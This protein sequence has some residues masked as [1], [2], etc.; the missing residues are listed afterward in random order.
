[1]KKLLEH[2][3]KNVPPEHRD[4]LIAVI[5]KNPDFFKQLNTEIEKEVKSGKSQMKASMEVMRKHQAELQK[6][7]QD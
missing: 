3:L 1:M 7:M 4:R 2:Q 6:L 5:S